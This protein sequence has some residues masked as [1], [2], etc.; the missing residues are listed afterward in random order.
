MVLPGGVNGRALVEGLQ[1]RLPGLDAVFMSGYSR[2]MVAQGQ[3]PGDQLR[4]IEKPCAPAVLLE[5]IRAAL[6]EKDGRRP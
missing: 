4:F 6:D 1:T 2:E 5:Q 3:P